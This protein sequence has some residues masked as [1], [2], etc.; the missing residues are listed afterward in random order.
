LG[1]IVFTLVASHNHHFRQKIEH[2]LRGSSMAQH[3]FHQHM[4]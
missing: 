4:D 1:M 3:H 2:H